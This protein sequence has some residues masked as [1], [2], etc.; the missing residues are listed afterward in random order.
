MRSMRLFNWLVFAILSVVATKRNADPA[1]YCDVCQTAVHQVY[2]MVEPRKRH[3]SL[4]ER[5]AETLDPN[6]VCNAGFLRDAATKLDLGASAMI[7][8]CQHLFD[9]KN[10]DVSFEQSMKPDITEEKLAMAVCI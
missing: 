6:S 8:T 4:S 9:R 10:I 3:E 1:M 2:G 5:T 7:A